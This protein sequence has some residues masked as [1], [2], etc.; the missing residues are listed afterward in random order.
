MVNNFQ[1]SA[2]ATELLNVF[3]YLSHSFSKEESK[4]LYLQCIMAK[5][6]MALSV[7]RE[8]ASKQR[9]TDSVS[10]SNVSTHLDLSIHSYTPLITIIEYVQLDWIGCVC[11]TMRPEHLKSHNGKSMAT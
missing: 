2:I 5:L 9:A 8:G 10:D 3:L 6:T 11:V 7:A 1:Q 4:I